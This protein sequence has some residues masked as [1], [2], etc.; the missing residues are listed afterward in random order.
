MAHHRRTIGLATLVNTAISVGEGAAAW[1]SGS[2]SVLVDSVHNL[3]DELALLC[4]YL[5]FFLPGYLSRQSQR[6]ANVLN[7]AGLIA[8][9]AGLVWVAAIRLR[10]P[11]TV[12]GWLPVATGLAAA[13]A[14]WG[15]AWLLRRPARA[16]AAIRLAYLHNL[17]DVGVSFAPVAAGALITLTGRSAF[18]ALVG[19]AVALWLVVSTLREI[20]SSSVALLWPER[21]MCGDEGG[22][23]GHTA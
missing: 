9:S 16:N 2:L 7:S 19:L 10:H 18:D 22:A 21:M 6:T 1:Y 13:G 3:S 11:T 23:T 17:G 12:A 14:N 5:A 20:R 4:L 8:V 15:V